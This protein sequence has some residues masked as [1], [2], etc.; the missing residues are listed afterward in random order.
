VVLTRLVSAPVVFSE[1][2]LVKDSKTGLLVWTG[3]VGEDDADAVIRNRALD[4]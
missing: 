3:Q 4:Q 1:G 2:N